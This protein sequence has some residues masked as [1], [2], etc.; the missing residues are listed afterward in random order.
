MSWAPGRL[1]KYKYLT[2][3][4]ETACMSYLRVKKKKIAVHCSTLNQILNWPHKNGPD[5]H[6]TTVQR[7]Y[8]GHLSQPLY[9]S[10]TCI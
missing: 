6:D 3:H 1:Q 9:N 10:Q 5:L 2:I 4:S 8:E 7:S